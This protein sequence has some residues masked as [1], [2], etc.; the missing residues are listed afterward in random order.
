MD[1]D[2]VTISQT[3]A[4]RDKIQICHVTTHAINNQ[5]VGFPAISCSLLLVN[6][7]DR[8]LVMVHQDNGAE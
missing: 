3:F 5:Q 4:Q 6:S 1:K 2:C 7:I 8:E